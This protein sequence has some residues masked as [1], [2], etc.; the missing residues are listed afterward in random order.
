M[1][2]FYAQDGQ[3]KGPISEADLGDLSRTGV[4]SAETLVWHSGMA[5]WRPFREASAVLLEPLRFCH[6]CGNGFPATD[7]AVFGESAVCA[8]CKPAF[9]QRLRQGMAST[10]TATLRFAG[11][12]VRVLAWGIDFVIVETVFLLSLLMIG[13]LNQGKTPK[14]I[15]PAILVAF[16]AGALMRLAYHIGFVARFGAT[17][18][19]MA[20][21]LKIVRP[22]GSPVSG[23]Q[24]FGRPFAMAI[25][26][27]ILGFGFLMVAWTREK[28][29]LH[30][31]ICGTRVVRTR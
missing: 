7:L 11:F 25:S 24:A 18:G 20:A 22:D 19:K 6:S 13:V 9:V 16:A 17:P 10:E 12:W 31:G 4:V 15:E 28:Q 26:A 1:N 2:W 29:A 8:A 27:M 21:G 30:D 23:G 14:Q 3:Q 5:E